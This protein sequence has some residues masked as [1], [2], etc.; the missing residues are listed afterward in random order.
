M[1]RISL[2]VSCRTALLLA[3]CVVQGAEP[4]AVEKV[5]AESDV[6]FIPFSH[7]DLFWGG[8]R[9]ECLARG[10]NLIAKAIRLAKQ[11]PEF[12]FLLEDEVF[13]ANYLDAHRGSQEVEDLK[14]L[15]RSGQI[16]IAP[17]WAAIY[18]ELPDGEA[19][20][21]NLVI[22]KRYAREVFGVDPQVAHLGD[23][24][25]Y[26]PQYPQLLR[27]AGVPFMV[28]TRMGPADKSLF[29]WKS[30]DGSRVLVWSSLK[31]YAWGTFVHSRMSEERKLERFR[32]DLADVRA[33]TDAPIL[34]HF[35]CDLWTP[36]DN[37]VEI[38]EQFNRKSPAR[39]IFAT[40]LEY[41]RRVESR[42]GI[43]EV[44][45]EIPSSWPNLVSSLPNL[46][47][48]ITPAT[49]TLLSAEKFAA[50]NDALGYASYPGR[51]FENLW[52]SLLEALDHNQDGQGGLPGDRG[53]I[54]CREVAALR[55]GQILRDMLR[56]LAERVEV[57]IAGSFPI[58]VFNPMSWTRDDVVRTHVTLFGEADPS[59]IAPFKKGMRLLDETGRPVPFYV[60]QYSEN[61][62]RALEM[63]FV[64]RDVPSLGYR[65]YYLVAAEQPDEFPAAATV[66]LDAERDRREPRR[67]LGSDVLENRFYRLSVDRA[68]G[69]FTLFD[70]ALNR[71]VCRDMEVAALEERGGNYIGIESPS[72]RT[73]I[74]TV[75]HMAVEENNAVR[76]VVRIELRLA[77]I[78]IVQ[79]LTLYQGLKRLDIENTVE[80]RTPRFLRIRQMFPT[81]V[82]DA[83]IHYGIPFGANASDNLIPNAGTRFGDEITNESWRRSRLVQGWL[84]AGAADG[85]LTIAADHAQFRLE[86]SAICA[87]MLR[88]TRF[89]SVK[90]V[91][92]EEIGS[93]HYPPPGIY[94]FRYS[95]S[96]ASGDWKATKAYRAGMSLNNPLLPVYVADAVSSKSLPPTR[97]F[98]TLKADNV[99]VSALKKADLG[100]SLV[101][102]V[103]EIE[104]SPMETPVE[105]LGRPAALGEV[106]LLEENLDQSPQQ[107]VRGGPYAIKTIRLEGSKGL[108]PA[109]KGTR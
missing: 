105:F 25:G 87:E 55:A 66:K 88:G 80:W 53:K 86:D 29:H 81:A 9:E 90:V 97:S 100:S 102:R 8:T 108:A 96:S 69:R 78:P 43:P 39:L 50:I 71:D 64:A 52:K 33:T 5:P 42:P 82:P 59:E 51:E 62:S 10:C 37:L 11:S 79:R 104:G 41:F 27:Q 98:C 6:S 70:K 20:V 49:N 58:V 46:W 93:M 32:K 92:G 63:V 1:N 3:V 67:P 35:G 72:G 74:S 22:G 31:S 26:T 73:L 99:V 28:M 101:L 45:G 48:P 65:T 7:L 30:P 107:V 61:I 40:P 77:D 23:L 83:A 36:P 75:E 15:V 76:T 24:P 14:R 2:G 13:V 89:T 91:R 47:P 16:E 21:R 17:K 85:G 34:M 103:Y 94:V 12:R 68:T 56:N 106:N 84:H 54:E 38:V 18:Q 19:Q 109:A 95:L 4:A 60:E 44:S 57:P